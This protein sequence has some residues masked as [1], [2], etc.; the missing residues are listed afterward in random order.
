MGDQQHRHADQAKQCPD[1]IDGAL[2]RP[3]ET[4]C[5]AEATE[6]SQHTQQPQHQGGAAEGGHDLGLH[7]L[8]HLGVGQ[9]HLHHLE[10]ILGV[11]A[12]DLDM[13]MNL[14]Q[15]HVAVLFGVIAASAEKAAEKRELFGSDVG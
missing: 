4:Q 5:D 15:V 7:R 11:K 13:G 12:A 14:A 1:D 3:E 10:P 8:G 6:H 9:G 2:L